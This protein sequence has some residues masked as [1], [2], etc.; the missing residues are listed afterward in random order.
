[1]AD[2]GPNNP[3]RGLAS[4]IT[5][6]QGAALFPALAQYLAGLLHA[7]EVVIGEA[8]DELHAHT[9]GVCVHGAI[10][11]NYTFPLAG[12]P[13]NETYTAPCPPVG[14]LRLERLFLFC[15]LFKVVRMFVRTFSVSLLA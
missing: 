10:Q 7:S 1:M 2:A 9:L 3:L 15:R 6:A 14:E 11:T 8:A 5:A 13:G 4:R 12:T